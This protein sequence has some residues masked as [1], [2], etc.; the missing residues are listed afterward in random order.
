MSEKAHAAFQDAINNFG[1]LL[2]AIPPRK[3]V[4]MFET[5]QA[6]EVRLRLGSICARLLWRALDCLDK[7]SRDAYELRHDIRGL[8][9]A[10]GEG[11]DE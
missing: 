1:K 10:F 11:V 3:R 8:F 2:D 9:T 7:E 6:V 5:M 4:L